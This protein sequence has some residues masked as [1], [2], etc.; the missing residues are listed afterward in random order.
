MEIYKFT[1]IGFNEKPLLYV[2]NFMDAYIKAKALL[3]TM[4]ED[5]KLIKVGEVK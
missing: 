1:C 2:N 3:D 5:F 4:K